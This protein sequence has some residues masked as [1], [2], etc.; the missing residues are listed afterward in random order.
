MYSDYIA[1]LNDRRF[2]DLKRFVHDR[3]TYNDESWTRE[4]Y[5]GRLRADAAAIPDLR[6]EIDLLV[7]DGGLLAARLL[8]D[9]SPSGPFLGL[10]TD[11]RRVRFSEHVFYR[12]TDERIDLVRSLIDVDAI[13]RQLT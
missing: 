4:Q 13:R 11:G 12:F 2:D 5:A 10:D 7:V 9:C 3:V 8:F 1:T 6:F